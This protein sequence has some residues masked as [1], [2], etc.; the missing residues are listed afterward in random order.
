MK[1]IHYDSRKLGPT[2]WSLISKR[3]ILLEYVDIYIFILV[4]FIINKVSRVLIYH[5]IQEY[6]YDVVNFKFRR[7]K[8]SWIQIILWDN[9]DRTKDYIC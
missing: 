6:V 3:V 7:K 9:S 2:S 1:I 5:L 8:I 4:V